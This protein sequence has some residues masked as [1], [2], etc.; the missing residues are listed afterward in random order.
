MGV[1]DLVPTNTDLG[2]N[3][4]A[5]N[6]VCLYITPTGKSRLP[7]LHARKQ[8]LP[9]WS[10]SP[11]ILIHSHYEHD[12]AKKRPPEF[13]GGLHQSLV[14]LREKHVGGE[15]GLIHAR[16]LECFL[17]DSEGSRTESYIVKGRCPTTVRTSRSLRCGIGRRRGRYGE[18]Q[19]SILWIIYELAA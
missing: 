11:T 18:R 6:V 19:I 14:Q 13:S 10:V 1:R 8:Q 16:T 9:A 5:R 4:R 15:H 3:T 12:V 2:Y 7:R 17:L